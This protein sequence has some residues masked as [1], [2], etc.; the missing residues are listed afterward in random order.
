MIEGTLREWEEYDGRAWEDSPAPRTVITGEHWESESLEPSMEGSEASESPF[1][2]GH[3]SEAEILGESFETMETEVPQSEAE[4]EASEFETQMEAE[5]FSGGFDRHRG[6]DE[7]ASETVSETEME[8]D[9]YASVRSAIAPEHANLSANEL[10]VILGG[11]PA[12]LVLHQLVHSPQ[13]RHATLAS[14]LGKA[15]RRSVRVHGRDLPIPAYL[16]LVS[17]LCREA[18]EHAEAE[19]GGP[20]SVGEIGEQ[21]AAGQSLMGLSAA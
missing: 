13:M 5:T 21:A 3:E 6:L 11:R 7:A 8:I 10:T 12:A 14:L 16:R 1:L 20:I 9:P 18:A 19:S 2:M 4:F 15:A 17:R